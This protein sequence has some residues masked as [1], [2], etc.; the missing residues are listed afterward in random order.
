MGGREGLIDT[1]VKTS[2]TG[3]IQRRLVKAMEDL[4]VKYDGTVRNSLGDVIQFLYGEDG[5]D[6]VWIEQQKLDSMK[7]SRSKLEKVYAYELDDENW[8]PVSYMPAEAAE[9]I[10]SL[11]AL[12][13]V[14]QAEMQ[15]VE[16]DRRILGRDIAPGGD[17]K[18]YL[19]VNMK[20]LIWNAQ[21]MF[22]I[23]PHKPSDMSPLDVIGEVERLQERLV[24][25]VGED[26]L[27]K[28][29]QEN[30]T[31][32]FKCM[33]RSSLA[34]KRVLQEYRLSKTAF[35]WVIGEIEYRFLQSQVSE[36]TERGGIEV[37]GVVVGFTKWPAWMR[38]KHCL[39]AP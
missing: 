19:P 24:V 3:Y 34:S 26:G 1:A 37:M 32:F 15:Q 21:K 11:P 9:E 38:S 5:M 36:G 2:E 33:L 31:L 4:S 25:V 12:Q 6:A 7:M 27:S 39:P 13:F 20:R 14:L 30:A 22:K 18:G 10:R 35:E 16:K 17:D 28:E 23:N 8:D 29:A